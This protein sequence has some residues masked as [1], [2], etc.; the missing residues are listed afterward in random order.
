MAV[1]VNV[2]IDNAGDQFID[3]TD[4]IIVTRVVAQYDFLIRKKVRVKIKY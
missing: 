2:V 4:Y 3:I 1:I